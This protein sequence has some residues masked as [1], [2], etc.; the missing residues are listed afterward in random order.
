MLGDLNIVI[1][2]SVSND[3]VVSSGGGDGR[4]LV[5]QTH[6]SSVAQSQDLP[7]PPS[8]IPRTSLE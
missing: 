8:C 5:T 7:M 6:A 1:Q 4:M 2:H 3:G